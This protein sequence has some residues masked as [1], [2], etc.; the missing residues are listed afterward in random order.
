MLKEYQVDPRAQCLQQHRRLD[1]GEEEAN[2]NTN[3]DPKAKTPPHKPEH[4]S[5]ISHKKN[6]TNPLYQP[7]WRNLY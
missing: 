1:K 5:N 2:S 6:K 4:K 3:S 7:K